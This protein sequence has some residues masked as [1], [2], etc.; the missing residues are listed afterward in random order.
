MGPPPGRLLRELSPNAAH[1]GAADEGAGVSPGIGGSAVGK[2]LGSA[3]GKA[4][5]NVQGCAG[6][7]VAVVVAVGCG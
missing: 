7:G 3:V 6:G 5:G 4:V 2:P 1:F